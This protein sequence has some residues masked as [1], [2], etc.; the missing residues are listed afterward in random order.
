M[1]IR[2]KLI[3]AFVATS[4]ASM[5]VVGAFSYAE[6]AAMLQNAA[7]RQLESLAEARAGD[8]AVIAE[9]L[10]EE[11]QLIESRTNLREQVAGFPGDPEGVRPAIQRILDDAQQSVNMVTR[12]T[13]YDLQGEV[14]AEAGRG[15][16]AE[17]LLGTV[18]R[19]GGAI[20]RYLERP[21][22]GLV[23]V[24]EAPLELDDRVVGRIASEV[25]VGRILS[26]ATNYE[27]LGETGELLLPAEFDSGYVTFLHPLRHRD[28]DSLIVL[29][30]EEASRPV[31]MALEGA[32]GLVRDEPD[33]RGTPVWAAVRPL[34]VLPG[35]IVVKVDA[36]EEL[37]PVAE[38]RR[39]LTRV[40][41]AVAALA[42]LAGS[43]VGT[44]MA[45]RLR[46]LNEVV[47]RVR[48]GEDGLRADESGEDEVSFLAESFNRLMDHLQGRDPR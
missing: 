22:R 3:F 17:R 16:S 15:P 10:R 30:V 47:G 42:I 43:L 33:Y 35:G 2:T 48:K 14:I 44:L 46:R 26:I 27:G 25:A 36:A 41:L 40:A 37:A 13:V 1:D 6:S 29:P 24:L 19:E 9:A 5:L 11:V 8:L 21:D 4:L 32:E 23:A 39:R 18:P 20:T 7:A 34:P 38:L 28:A 45:R 31:R 12:I